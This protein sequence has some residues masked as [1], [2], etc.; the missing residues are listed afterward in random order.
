MIVEQLVLLS[1]QHG[2]RS[3][4]SGIRLLKAEQIGNR[5]VF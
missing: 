2:G 4:P 3:F 1:R 5:S